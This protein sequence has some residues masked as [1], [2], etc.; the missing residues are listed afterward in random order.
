MTK[1]Q[2]RLLVEG[3]Y[4]LAVLAEEAGKNLDAESLRGLI[5]AVAEEITNPKPVLYDPR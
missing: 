3:S 2:I 1:A 4:V 5:D